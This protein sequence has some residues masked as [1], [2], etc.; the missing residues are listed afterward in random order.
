MISSFLKFINRICVAVIVVMIL[1]TS[2]LI[3][4]GLKIIIEPN[5]TEYAVGEPI[6]MTVKFRNESD[7][8]IRILDV[9]S[10]SMAENYYLFYEVVNPNGELQVR[11]FTYIASTRILIP[12]FKGEG[13]LPGE[14]KE[15]CF[16]YPNW[17][18]MVEPRS[19][20]QG[21]TFPEPGEYRFRLRYYVPN[22]YSKL[23]NHGKYARSNEIT[24]KIRDC[25]SEEKAIL[26]SLYKKGPDVTSLGDDDYW[27]SKTEFDEEAL[28][29]AIR[30]YPENEMVKYPKFYLAMLLISSKRYDEAIDIL[31]GLL[32]DYPGF[33]EEEIYQ[34]LG[35]CYVELG[36]REEALRYLN[37]I[38]EKRP[39]LKDH[40]N[41]M[42]CM[43]MADKGFRWGNE[44][45]EAA[46]SWLRKRIHE[47]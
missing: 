45:L 5:K 22:E 4:E 12:T 14:V 23:W 8:I 33:R 16:I 26:G 46:R 30:L 29:E 40:Y 13:L 27:V 41:F 24:I 6:K 15:V 3:A 43:I 28:R 35:R 9:G 37:A 25:T 20:I 19:K 42:R 18:W 47:N 7:S 17:S 38:M 34:H 11:Y 39:E 2:S 44:A 31:T 10:Y 21:L 32:K 1:S 36:D